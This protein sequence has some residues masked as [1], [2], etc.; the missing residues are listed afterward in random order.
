MVHIW[1]LQLWWNKIN[2]LKKKK[3]F[4]KYW[5]CNS[6]STDRV[7]S[8]VRYDQIN[9]CIVFL[10]IDVKLYEL[11]YIWIVTLPVKL[12]YRWAVVSHHAH[13]VSF[14]SA[15]V[16]LLPL[17]ATVI[18]QIPLRE[19][20]LS[21]FW[22]HSWF[23]AF[24]KYISL[25]DNVCEECLLKHLPSV[26]WQKQRNILFS[27]YVFNVCFCTTNQ[28]FHSLLKVKDPSRQTPKLIGASRGGIDH[29]GQCR[30]KFS[31]N[32]VQPRNAVL[33]SLR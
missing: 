32:I 9:T 5:V 6:V 15:C 29:V 13:L 17:N 21:I 12:A 24:L 2:N 10:F 19:M 33:F 16:L 1:L 28:K 18:C 7:D 22:P 31:N 25:I 3:R 4:A 20:Q 11:I 8:P 27:V 30:S 23:I 14:F 26:R